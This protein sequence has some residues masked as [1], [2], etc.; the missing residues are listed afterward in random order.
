[1]TWHGGKSSVEHRG[2]TKRGFTLVELLVVI[3]IIGILIALLLP[4]VQSIREAARQT[5]CR[6]RIRQIALA[7]QNY[8][9]MFRELP[10]YS[11]EVPP[12]L[13]AFPSGRQFDARFNG[14]NWMVQA[15]KQM[16]QANL[17]PPLAKIGAAP[18]VS[19]TDRVQMHVQAA[20]ATFHCPTRRDAD[21]Y[22][23]L[24]PYRSRYGESGGRTDYAMC[25]GSATISETDE[26]VIHH[27]DEGVWRLGG[28]TPLARLLDGLSN[29]YLIGEK[30]MDSLRYTTGDCFGDR[31]PLAGYTGIGTTSH[32]YVR[33]A[34]RQPSL[35]QPDN[36]LSCHDFGSAHPA[37][38]NAAMADGSVK[39]LTY[40]QD[41]EIHRASASIDGR[42][43]PTYEH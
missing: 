4:A 16:E 14:G 22:P 42:E 1:M 41:I 29:T 26:R 6:N 24:E 43:I 31:A 30:A 7:C 2:C 9:S 21:A 11:G 34:A 13:V 33:F 27:E 20:V 15:M 32:S 12:F 36:C 3:A 10:G 23:L 38:W 25:G 5:K 37:G 17:A 35:D 40:T 28:R 8:E 39:M 19:P 18:L